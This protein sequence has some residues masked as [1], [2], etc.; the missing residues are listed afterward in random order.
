ML[1]FLSCVS[2]LTRDI[3][4]A[5]FVRLFVCLSVRPSRSS[6]LWLVAWPS[7][8]TLVFDR[9]TFSVLRSTCRW[10]ATTYVGNER[11]QSQWPW[12]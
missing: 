8:R 9:R 1:Q 2:T 5:I 7:D 12:V 4:I 10:R 3:D 11:Y 6:I